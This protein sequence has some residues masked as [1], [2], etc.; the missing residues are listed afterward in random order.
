VREDR[1]VRNEALY[2]ELNE[3]VRQVEE[4]LD[5]HGVVEPPTFGEYFCECGLENC[6]E[7]ILLT[8]DEYEAVRASALR[9]AIVPEHLVPDVER[10]VAQNARFMTIEKLEGERELVLEHDPRRR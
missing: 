1:I 7:K 4:D 5:A 10:V 2:R 9:F 3:R 6:F 8:S